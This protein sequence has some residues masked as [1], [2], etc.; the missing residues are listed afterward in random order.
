MISV[1]GYL[2]LAFSDLIYHLEDTEIGV[3]WLQ[4]R[5]NVEVSPATGKNTGI[6]LLLC[7]AWKYIPTAISGGVDI[8]EVLRCHFLR[9]MSFQWE[10]Q[11]LLESIGI[12]SSHIL[13]LCF[14]PIVFQW[15]MVILSKGCKPDNFEQ[16]ISLK[17]R[18]TTIW[19]PVLSF[20]KCESFLEWSTPDIFALCETNLD[21]S[22]DFGNFSVWQGYLPLIRKDSITQMHGLA[23]Y[24][25]EDFLFARDASLENFADSYLCFRLVLLHSVSYFFFLY[26]SPS[27]SLCKLF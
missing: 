5:L 22:I 23:V 11:K 6:A 17:L 7:C 16:H 20:V 15:I 10:S 2:F 21:D 4:Q 24:V 19:G 13:R 26:W 12:S 25:K 18:L 1:D 3:F 14:W 8:S 27:L 9:Q